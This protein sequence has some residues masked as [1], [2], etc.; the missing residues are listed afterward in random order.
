MRIKNFNETKVYINGSI[1]YLGQNPWIFNGTI[2]ENILL[3]KEFDKDAF[4]FVLKYSALEEDVRT[5]EEGVEKK[6]GESGA[7]ISGGQKARVALARCL[8]QK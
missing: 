3:D 5:W 4:D 7:S 6:V 8:Y 1:G 2:K